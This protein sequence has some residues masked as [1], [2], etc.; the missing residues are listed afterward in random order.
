M[1]ACPHIFPYKF[2]FIL[3]K[4]VESFT[5]RYTSYLFTLGIIKLALIIRAVAASSA[6]LW[7]AIL[8]HY[9]RDGGNFAILAEDNFAHGSSHEFRCPSGQFR[10]RACPHIFPYKFPFI[11][12]KLV[13]S[14][15]ER[16]TSYLFTLGIIK[17]ALIIRAVAAIFKHFKN[18]TSGMVGNFSS[19]R[20]LFLLFTNQFLLL[21][22]FSS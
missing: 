16:Y 20:N 21:H 5:E 6:A 8:F 9:R 19:T 4:L 14:F 7:A 3:C 1:R 2:P 18:R 22:L 13:E 10:V 15:T 17:L 11:L 12:C